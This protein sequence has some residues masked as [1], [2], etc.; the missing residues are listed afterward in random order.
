MTTPKKRNDFMTPT[1]FLELYPKIAKV[2]NAPALGYLLMLK[3]VRGR[4][5]KRGCEIS[6]SDVLRLYRREICG[7]NED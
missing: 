1:E 6:E 2:W 4:K 5:L 3:L 7:I